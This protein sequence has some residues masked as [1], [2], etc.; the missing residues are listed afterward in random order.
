MFPLPQ[1]GSRILF[2]NPPYISSALIR[3]LVHSTGSTY[4]S[5]F[6]RSVM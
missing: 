4:Q 2:P 6:S 5:F 1:H 3:A